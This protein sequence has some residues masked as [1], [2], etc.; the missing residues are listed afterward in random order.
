MFIPC[1]PY[2]N[3]SCIQAIEAV[4]AFFHKNPQA[5]AYFAIIN[6]EGNAKVPGDAAELKIPDI[7]VSQIL[8]AV[9]LQAKKLN[10]AAYVFSVDSENGKV[11]HVNHLPESLRS[12]SFDARTW[13]ARVTETLGGKVGTL[14]TKPSDEFKIAVGWRQRRWRARCRPQY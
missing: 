3:R 5:D 4:V 11:I 13:A 7:F 14:F 9:V 10:K 8:Q 6:V 2:T 12:K 1:H